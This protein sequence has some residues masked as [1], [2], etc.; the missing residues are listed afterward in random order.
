[1]NEP[2]DAAPRFTVR[3]TSTFVIHAPE[4]KPLEVSRR[5]VRFTLT[6]S[7]LSLNEIYVIKVALEQLAKLAVEP[8]AL[9]KKIHD[10]L[11]LALEAGGLE[12]WSG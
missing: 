2:I 6:L 11:L 12:S 8:D 3:A 7:E 5:A 4:H 10:E 1:M 9:S